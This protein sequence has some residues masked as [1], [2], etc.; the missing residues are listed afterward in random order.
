MADHPLFFKLTNEIRCEHF[1]ARVIVEGRALM[2]FED[3]EWWCHGV[4]PGGLTEH[5]QGPALAYAGFKVALGNI[6]SDLAADTHSFESFQ[7]AVRA[8]VEEA[9]ASEAERWQAARSQI[10]AGEPVED[11]FSRLDR[12]EGQRPSGCRV[13]RIE[14]VQAAEEEVTLAQAA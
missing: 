7:V 10:R 11:F 4:E 5:G 8:F 13:D 9:D 2:A 12:E 14:Y 3:S 6:L 1:A